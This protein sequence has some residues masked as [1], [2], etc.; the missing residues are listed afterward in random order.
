MISDDD[1]LK[2]VNGKYLKVVR[3]RVDEYGTPL[4]PITI[5]ASDGF[6]LELEAS[7][8]LRFTGF[9]VIP[10]ALAAAI[11]L[12][13]LGARRVVVGTETKVLPHFLGLISFAGKHDS[14]SILGGY[15]NKTVIGKRLLTGRR[16]T[17][18]FFTGEV[19]INPSES[20]SVQC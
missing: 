17:I 15:D 19:S 18:D 12:R 7:I 4:V 20:E 11:G 5:V 13:N 8:N 9:M 2:D 6:E 16:L 10:E 1:R 14:I 3:G